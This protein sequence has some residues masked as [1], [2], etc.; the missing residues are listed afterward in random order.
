MCT[1]LTT[2]AAWAYNDPDYDKYPAVGYHQKVSPDTKTGAARRRAREEAVE[3][4]RRLDALPYPH[5]IE[6]L[7]RSYLATFYR[8]PDFTTQPYEHGDNASKLTGFW[9]SDGLPPLVPT[10]RVAGRFVETNG[11]L[12]E[13]W[14]NQTDSG[15]NKLTPSA[16]RW[17]ERS[18]TYAGIARAMASQ[19][20]PWIREQYRK[21]EK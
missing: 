19:W 15:Q 3:T 20:S 8:K 21:R 5:A 13:R 1:Y 9:T 10:D 11:K 12:V 4:V 14:E 6:N 16:A 17:L 2:S 7:G 18:N